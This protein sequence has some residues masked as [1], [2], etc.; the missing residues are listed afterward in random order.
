MPFCSPRS[1]SGK[2]SGLS[3]LKIRNI[4]AVQ[5]PMPRTSTS[6]A[7]ISSSP[8]C[9]Q[10]CTWMRPSAK[11]C[12]RSAMYSVLRSESPQARS[13]GRLRASTFCGVISPT[14][15]QRRSQTLCAA[16]TEICWPTIARVSVKKG[17]PR[18]TRNTFGC[19]RTMP[20]M[21]GSRRMSA[22]F[23]RSQYSGFM[24]RQIGEQ[25]LRLHPHHT[26]L[27]RGERQVHGAAG[28]VRPHR[29]RLGEIERE[30]RED[31]LHAAVV[32]LGAGPQIVEDRG[33]FR[34][35]TDV[36]APARLLDAP[37]R[38]HPHFEAYEVPYP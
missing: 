7:M 8:I 37:H 20:A 3:R 30:E 15:A 32:D 29:A 31:P 28:D 4:S 19:A 22:R 25:V 24:Q 18:E 34:V 14:Q 13:S 6:S 11:C 33:R 10:R 9:G 5:R 26:V 35:E 16:L 17:S 27:V 21:T 1:S 23:A 2:T 36:P 38:F 12:A